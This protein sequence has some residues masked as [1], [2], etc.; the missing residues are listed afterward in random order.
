MS[1][2][3]D[4]TRAY[5]L[6]DQSEL[7]YNFGAEH[8]MQPRRLVA[9]MDLL[10]SSGL[11]QRT[12]EASQLPL[13]AATDEELGLVHTPDYIAAVQRLSI[14]EE[15]GQHELQ[16]RNNLALHY[17]FGEGDT[18]A[19]PGMHEAAAR[20]AGGTL[21]AL[22]AVMGLPAGGPAGAEKI[23]PLHVFHPAGG[24]HHAWAER[25]SGFC[26]Y[27]DISVAIAHVLRSY[28]A[29]VLYLD[30]D[31]HHGDGVQRSFYDEPRVM[32]V[33]LH[34]TG[35]YLF[36]GTGDILELGRGLG[37]GYSINLPL[38]PF[39]EDESYVE[40]MNAL[41]PPLVMSFAPDVI[42]SQHGCDT[43]AWDPLT[44]LELTTRS[45]QA[46]VRCAHQLAHTYCHGR[47]VALGGGGYDQ[48]RVVPRVWSMLWADMSGQALPEQLP[49]QW[50]E[51]WHPAWEA[52]KEQE[53]LEQELA[54][55]TSFFA[56]FPTTFEDQAEHF[57]PQPRRWS[58]SLE[59]RRTAAMLRQILVPSPIRKVFS[60]AQRQSP[61]TDLYDL[62]HPGG[63]HAEI[64]RA[65]V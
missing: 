42:I 10:E 17:G 44:H 36:P 54:G 24:W 16:E 49:E 27:N 26:I 35:R 50:V 15:A 45:I 37:R 25:A 65:H 53:V 12:G 58:I 4:H 19:L 5:L 38:E 43:H 22:S 11:W 41:L 21:V 39:T 56:D 20:I 23:G 2:A 3:D 48:F 57:P 6:F 18:P 34:E 8:P 61:L 62:L 13:R 52:V 14:P 55:K 32:T 60:A 59:N 29:K 1:H 30:F 40:V 31:V 7:E 47:W 64:G 28:E 63:A 9:L 33:S 46:Q 51:R